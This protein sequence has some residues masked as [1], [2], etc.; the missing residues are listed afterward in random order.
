MEEYRKWNLD[1]KSEKITQTFDGRSENYDGW[2]ELMIDV[3]STQWF[4]WRFIL[5]QL[6]KRKEPTTTA[7]TR[8]TYNWCNLNGG[9]LVV[10]SAMLWSHLGRCMN[11]T[12]RR[13]RL[14]TA[15]EKLNGF[16]RWRRLHWDHGDGEEQADLSRAK[17]F[18]DFP[19]CA[20]F[21]GLQSH[22]D[23][24]IRLK[25]EVAQSTPE[26]TLL[27]QL[28]GILPLAC[29]E[30]LQDDP[31]I[32]TL[33]DALDRITAKCK[34]MNK[35]RLAQT[36]QSRREASLKEKGPDSIRSRCF[37]TRTSSTATTATS[38]RC[39]FPR[40][41]KEQHRHRHNQDCY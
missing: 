19:R 6:V 13:A 14:R 16:E 5:E 1:I 23:E 12:M 36:D 40:Q 37:A 29:S 7:F 24:W 28:L 30:Q 3:C 21:D 11:V 8:A 41:R 15:G 33:K 38:T 18:R 4:G 17:Y 31:T 25:Q 39:P 34:R 2:T 22:V 9:Q 32:T 35:N 27:L 20:T 26:K 10:L